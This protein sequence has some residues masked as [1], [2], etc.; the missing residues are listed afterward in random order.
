MLQLLPLSFGAALQSLADE[1]GDAFADDHGS[2]I[3]I[4]ADAIGHDRG[5]G[6][7]QPLQPMDFA[8]L[9]NHGHR[10]GGWPHFACTRTVMAG[11]DLVQHPCVQGGI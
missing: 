7:T 5:I 8:K 9:V 10:I 6:D 11:S 2:H 1:I 4:G 3:G